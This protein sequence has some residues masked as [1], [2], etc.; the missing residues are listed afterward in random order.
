MTK[1]SLIAL[2]ICLVLGAGIAAYVWA[3]VCCGGEGALCHGGTQKVPETD[4]DYY[5]HVDHDLPSYGEGHT[6]WVYIKQGDLTAVRYTMNLQTPDPQPV[7]MLFGRAITMA[8]SNDYTY[9]F[10][11]WVGGEECDRDPEDP[12]VYSI[13]LDANCDPQ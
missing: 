8:A 1:K 2:S 5:F 12:A 11:C 10:V 4:C 3:T 6:V 13:N 7:C 9:W